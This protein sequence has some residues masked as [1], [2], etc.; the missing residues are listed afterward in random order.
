MSKYEENKE[1]IKTKRQK[2]YQEHKV[3]ILRKAKKRYDTQ[4]GLAKNRV[5]YEKCKKN[6]KA[7]KWDNNKKLKAMQKVSGQE[8]PTCVYC[9]CDDIRFLEINHINGGGGAESKRRNSNLYI[10]ILY[11]N[12]RTDDLDVTCRPCNAVYYLRLKY[13]QSY[14]KVVWMREGDRQC[15]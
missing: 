6:G 10:S 2:N 12:R 9:G 3:E 1:A 4:G 7:K 11:H 13:G 5:Y 14:F 15:E 8:V